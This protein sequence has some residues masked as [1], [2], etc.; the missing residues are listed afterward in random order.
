MVA[1]EPDQQGA[2]R[3]RDPG[4]QENG[5]SALYTCH[6][7]DP[8]GSDNVYQVTVEAGDDGG[9]TASLQ[10]IATVHP[11]S[12]LAK[13]A[14]IETK[15]PPKGGNIEIRGINT[16][17][18]GVGFEPTIP[19]SQDKRLAGARTRPLCDPS[20]KRISNIADWAPAHNT[21]P[22]QGSFAIQ[23]AFSRQGRDS[24]PPWLLLGRSARVVPPKMEPIPKSALNSYR[25]CGFLTFSTIADTLVTALFQIQNWAPEKEN[26]HAVER[27]HR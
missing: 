3:Q 23:V 13:R 18:E 21:A 11:V 25:H 1:G 4:R 2:R 10:A 14:R 7:T 24:N 6:A 16:V 5:A 9:N 12:A 8:E 26:I 19:V 20:T 15:N 17:A 22:N 27:H